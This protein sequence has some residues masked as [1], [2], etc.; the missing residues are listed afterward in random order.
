[1]QDGIGGDRG[2]GT[3]GQILKKKKLKGKH[4]YLEIP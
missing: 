4:R 2:R 1:M 3:T